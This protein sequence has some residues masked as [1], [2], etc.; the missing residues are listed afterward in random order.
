MGLK[1]VG[2]C[3]GLAVIANGHRDEVVLN[4]GIFDAGPRAQEGRHLEM[5]GGAKACLEK[6]PFGTD[7][8]LGK[9]VQF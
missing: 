2:L 1:A 3:G 8:P 7:Q 5:V 9:E 4:I 6:Q